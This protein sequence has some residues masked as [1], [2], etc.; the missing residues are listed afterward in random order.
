MHFRLDLWHAEF[1]PAVFRDEE[2]RVN[3]QRSICIEMKSIERRL[4]IMADELVKF[5]VVRRG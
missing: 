5:F 1:F 4:K 3:R 2:Q